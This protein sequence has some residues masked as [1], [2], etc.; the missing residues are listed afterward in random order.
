MMNNKLPPQAYTRETLAEAFEWLK[1]Q[2][3]QVQAKAQNPDLLVSL[4][5]HACRRGQT[6]SSIN[7][8]NDLKYLA[9]NLE[10]FEKDETFEVEIPQ[11]AKPPTTPSSSPQEVSA[12]YPQSTPNTTSFDLSQLQT[13]SS[14]HHVIHPPQMIKEK[15]SLE[16]TIPQKIHL[17]D[18]LDTKSQD[19]VSEVQEGLN[20][21]SPEEALRMLLVLGFENYNSK[22]K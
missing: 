16:R 15:I 18:Q 21:S 7:F 22:W 20:L 9:K 14:A 2:P 17:Y 4:Y 8:K 12:P 6:P 3:Q 10:D 13:S 1:K 11:S 5:L 19:M